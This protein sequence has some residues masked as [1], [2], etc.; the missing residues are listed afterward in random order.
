M[1]GV[2]VENVNQKAMKTCRDA[3]KVRPSE[4]NEITDRP[5]PLAPAPCCR[6]VRTIYDSPPLS[7]SSNCLSVTV[8]SDSNS[9]L[10]TS[11]N[12]KTVRVY[13]HLPLL[14]RGYQ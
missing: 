2:A 3:L 4:R 8:S 6:I 13:K 7:P 10:R 5:R 11:V 12:W 1:D 14:A 9:R